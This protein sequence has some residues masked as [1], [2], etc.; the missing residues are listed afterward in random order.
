MRPVLWRPCEDLINGGV[1]SL[2]IHQIRFWR[3]ALGTET[4]HPR[5]SSK[6]VILGSLLV[7]E[8]G[9]NQFRFVSA[10]IIES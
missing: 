7:L 4:G 6:R 2:E 5:D 3:D 8:I 10:N 1:E 9:Q